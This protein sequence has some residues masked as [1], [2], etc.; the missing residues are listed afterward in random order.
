MLEEF[1]PLWW[2]PAPQI[3]HDD[4]ERR[5]AVVMLDTNVLGWILSC[6]FAA[7]IFCLDLDCDCCAAI[8]I[9][10]QHTTGPTNIN[11]YQNHF[12]IYLW[13]NFSRPSPTLSAN[14]YNISTHKPSMLWSLSSQK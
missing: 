2:Q 7:I 13:T 11:C 6:W 10:C 3:L 12:T 4:D 8:E 1:V 9:I 14:I 5:P